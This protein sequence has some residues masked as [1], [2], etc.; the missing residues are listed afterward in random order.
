MDKKFALTALVLLL[1]FSAIVPNATYCQSPPPTNPYVYVLVWSDDYLLLKPAILTYKQDLENVGFS[2]EIKSN[3]VWP[4]LPNTAEGIRELLQNEALTHEMA[5]VLLV[6]DVPYASYEMEIEG[7]NYTFPNDQFYM[8]LDGNWSD[9]DGNG[10][11]DMHTNETGDLEP[12]IWVG[13]LFASTVPGDETELLINYFDKNHRFRTGELTLPRRALAYID[14]DFLNPGADKA[15]SSLRMIYGNETTLVIDRETTNATHYKNMLNDT[16]GFEW[17]HLESHGNF[18]NHAF[19]TSGGWTYISSSQIQSVDPRAF[20]YNILACDS[21]DFTRR[22]MTIALAYIGGAYIF[23][24]TY[25]LLVVSSTKPGA[26]TSYS[27]FYKPVSEGKCVGQAFKEWF[28]KHGELS[29]LYHYGLTILGDPTLR[30]PRV[31]NQTRDIGIT[32]VA[33]SDS[34]YGLTE[35]P[36]GWNITI[37][38][39]VRNEGVFV[40]KFNVTVYSDNNT[41]VE[42]AVTVFPGA[43]NLTFVWDTTGVAE[44]EYTIEAEVSMVLGENDTDDNTMVDGTI[45]V[46]IMGDLN[47][48]GVIN[49]LDLKRVKL[50][51]SGYIVEPFADIDGNGEVNILDVKIEKLI[52]SGIL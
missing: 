8:D 16:L 42:H 22:N 26:M 6:G 45:R 33:A 19:K 32:S 29:P 39:A 20:F 13:R 44:G 34:H 9:F 23:A 21:A 15:N 25:G 27:D 41:V 2:V 31:Y 40:E 52:Y 18:K 38:V 7:Y 48:D 17:L 1:L 50:A 47:D 11:Y 49:I 3:I 35:V 46:R 24:D 28:E 36:S 14:D 51:Y 4:F 10:I 43:R 12:E 37:D 30:T 5:G